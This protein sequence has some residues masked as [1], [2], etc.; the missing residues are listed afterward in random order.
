MTDVNIPNQFHFVFGLRPQRQPFH[1]AHYLCLES[2]LQVNHPEAIYFYYQH[3]PYGSYWDAIRPKLKLERV[4]PNQLV[5]AHRYKEASVE[6][7]RYAHH[8]DFIRL[9][10]VIE[11]GGI[12][13]DIDT[14]FV[15]PFP[16][17]L[18]KKAFVLGKE[19]EIFDRKTNKPRLSL[20]N[21]L[22]MCAPGAEF[23]RR[24]LEGM[25]AHFD[26][27][28]SNHSTLL[29]QELAEQFPD[30]VHVEPQRSFYFFPPSRAGFAAL[31][32]DKQP[33]PNDVYSVHLWEHLWWD[34]ARAD[35]TDFHQGL[36]TREY[37]AK[38][39]TTYSAA[40][41]PFL[42]PQSLAHTEAGIIQRLVEAARNASAKVESELRCGVALAIYPH[43]RKFWPRAKEG[44]RLARA[45]QAYVEASKRLVTRN[46]VEAVILRNVIES[47]EYGIFYQRLNPEDV[48]IDVGA[49]IG[50][51]SW[52]AYWQGSRNIHAY[53]AEPSNF[54]VLEGNLKGLRGISV[55]YGAVFSNVAQLN[56]L[57]HSGH[58]F[59]N[60]GGG[61]V[62]FGDNL[63]AFHN[64]G[65][66]KPN[67]ELKS[68][69]VISFDE[70]LSKFERVR[71]LKLDCEGSEYPI[72]L[73]SKLL[74]KIDR[75]S[76]EYHV[77]DEERMRFVVPEAQVEGHGSYNG[78]TIRALLTAQGFEVTLIAWEELGLF[79]AVRRTAAQSRAGED[80][81]RPPD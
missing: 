17:E 32:E 3:E 46:A 5:T 65:H 80:G 78:E 53:E 7:Y 44:L 33:I 60:T 71:L 9:E 50:A 19:G 43:V 1:L 54:A 66:L 11:R 6:R 15:R 16:P 34:R 38:E 79:N 28:W 31:F 37:V 12:Y 26:G 74:H 30:L 64:V 2:C 67:R 55:N 56:G 72:L 42:P 22:I 68:T 62:I 13:A 14:L 35:F 24:W 58:V 49:H 36:L 4:G 69:P 39:E 75:I 48:V 10:K 29:P 8:A 57:T 45:H 81:S 51:F 52:A 41:R 21:A 76:G 70:V 27:S 77:I 20:C 23:G 61:S 59:S 40:A 73:T 63:F 18:Y 47:D 25:S